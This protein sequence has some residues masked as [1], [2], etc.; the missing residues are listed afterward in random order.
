MH[1]YY[2]GLDRDSLQVTADFPIDNT[3]AGVN[4]E[5]EIRHPPRDGTE[6]LEVPTA[7]SA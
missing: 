7:M 4:G 5:K 2:T 1:D 6:I 3:P